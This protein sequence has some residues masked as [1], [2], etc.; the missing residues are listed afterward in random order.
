MT[1]KLKPGTLEKLKGIS[2]ATLATALF[3]RGLR[4]QMIQDVLPLNSA[5]LP[6]VGEAF[7][8]R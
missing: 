7:T 4:N 2:T 6:M 5:A 8:L 1:T 3:K